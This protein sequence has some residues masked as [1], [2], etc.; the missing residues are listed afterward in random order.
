MEAA[1]SVPSRLEDYV[2]FYG[3]PFV[4]LHD[5]EDRVKLLEINKERK[6][7][8]P[9]NELEPETATV[10]ADDEVDW[11]RYNP[12]AALK[13]APNITNDVLLEVLQ[14]SIENIQARVAEENQVR[15][16]EEEARRR[17][18]EANMA[19]EASSRRSEPY[20]PIIITPDDPE[21]PESHSSGN[22]QNTKL[23]PEL[24]GSSD[25]RSA[26]G[27]I[28]LPFQPKKKSRFALTR[29][30]QRIGEKEAT[31]KPF[32]FGG[33]P[34]KTSIGGSSDENSTS[35]KLRKTATVEC[36]SCLDDF[37]PKEMVKVICHS[38]C[39]DCFERLI[40]TAVQNEQQWPPKCCLNDIPFRT[41]LRYVSKDLGKTYKDRAAE[42]KIPVGERI[43]CNQ[44][45]CGLWVRPDH[46]NLG[47]GIA[48]CAN[49]HWTCTICRGPQHD[50]SD[51]PQDRDLALTNALAEEEGWQHCSQCQALV[52][53]REACQHMTCRCGYQFCYVCNQRW[54]TCT[55]TMD[56]LNA[57]KAGAATR[58][59]ERLRRE[60]EAESELQDALR[61]IEE[62][63]REE[64]LKAEL[65][66][67]ETERQEE[68]R[69]QRELE[70]RVRLESLRR[71]EIEVKYQE[72]RALLDQVHD[73]Q[74]V[75]VRYQH[76]KE[77]ELAS[78]EAVTSTAE[79][80]A[81][82]QKE[83]LELTGTASQKLAA[84]EQALATEYSL[85]V[86]EEKKTE[87]AYLQLLEG[88]FADKPTGEARVEELMQEFRKKMDKGWRAWGRWRNEEVA[89]YKMKVEEEQTIRE[90]VMYSVKM[91]HEERID[92]ERRELGRR[93]VAEL[94]WVTLVVEERAR[95]LAQM[96]TTEIDDGGDSFS[97]SGSD[98]EE[99]D[100]VVP[101]PS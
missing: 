91:R 54:R 50:N 74:E 47:L 4:T 70:E 55:C 81:K 94:R 27:L 57:V 100:E 40:A 3:D 29:I 2:G 36:V 12:P 48:R 5:F 41:I 38:Y 10:K 72:Y 87:D 64:A 96:E 97:M 23:F 67:Q 79:L 28:V 59:Q 21:P 92:N 66:R 8:T 18:A 60:A 20:L 45:D 75:L 90:E 68:E 69:R 53:H 93:Q 46:V 76:D 13:T 49:A 30:L 7:D 52:E 9:S 99:V 42:W 63:E 15:Q 84:K 44:S 77:K 34:S 11:S 73:L 80:E 71:H 78:H 95:V 65:L 51:C 61:Q 62:F 17:E 33:N 101:G 24:M 32:R 19:Q 31:R 25:G 35:S 89:R 88:F 85:R 82:Q 98:E 1:S 83:H 56:Q 58:R 6:E 43:Y 22:Q 16:L 39:R 86:L 14:T 26:T 37:N